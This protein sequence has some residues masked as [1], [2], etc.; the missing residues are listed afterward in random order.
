MVRLGFLILPPAIVV[1][2][3]GYGFLKPVREGLYTGPI[4]LTFFYQLTNWVW[5]LVFWLHKKT[6][7]EE[8][9]QKTKMVVKGKTWDELKR[10]HGEQIKSW[11]T[12]YHYYALLH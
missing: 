4:W 7:A 8:S 10:T 6:H 3:L 11:V 12:D 2:T 1:A 9:E 5:I